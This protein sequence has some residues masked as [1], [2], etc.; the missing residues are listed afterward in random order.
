[1]VV[2]GRSRSS[3]VDSSPVMRCVNPTPSSRRSARR[4]GSAT[5]RSEREWMALRCSWCTLMIYLSTVLGT[6]HA[7]HACDAVADPPR[8]VS[9]LT[10]RRHACYSM[11]TD[12]PKIRAKLPTRDA[13]GAPSARPRHACHVCHRSGRHDR[14]VGRPR[15]GHKLPSHQPERPGKH[16]FS[17]RGGDWAR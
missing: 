15:G 1:M 7:Y 12:T 4:V 16:G 8:H 9:G 6:R 2:Q 13:P 11:D 14:P 10:A 17:V 3:F 5:A